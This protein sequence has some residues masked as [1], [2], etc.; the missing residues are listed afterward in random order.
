[1][2]VSE[3]IEQLEWFRHE[4]GDLPVVIERT[5][6]EYADWCCYKDPD[7]DVDYNNDYKILERG[8]S[9]GAAEA[10]CPDGPWC[11]LN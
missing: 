1:M 4:Y 8:L 3:L 9:A 5:E 7:F 10:S 6:V 11:F 2:N